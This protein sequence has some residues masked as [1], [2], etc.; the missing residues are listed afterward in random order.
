MSIRFTCPACDASYTIDDDMRGKKMRCR[1]CDESVTVP[2]KEPK[3]DDGV[4]DPKG[5]G[6]PPVRRDDRRDRDDHDGPKSRREKDA[7]SSRKPK[8]K[9]NLLL[10][11]VAIGGGGIAVVGVTLLLVIVI[12]VFALKSSD[13]PPADPRIVKD[14]V[15]V[16]PV[17]GG[18][19]NVFFGPQA[20]PNALPVDNQPAPDKIAAA[21][22]QSVK[23]STVYLRVTMPSGGVAEG[24]GFFA[25]EPGIVITNAHVVGMMRADSKLPANVDVVINSGEPNEVTLRG[26]VL[27]VDRFTDLAV[28]RVNGPA[29]SPLTINSASSLTDLQK[30]YYFGFPFGRKLGTN[31]TSS[32]AAVSSL[33][34]DPSG[35]IA[36]VQLTGNMQPGNS[37]GPVVD[38]AG[39]VVGVARAIISGTGINFAIP[40]DAIKEILDG[41]FADTT[42]G[43]PYL[44]N[45]ETRLP[46]TLK[47]IDPLARVKSMRVDIWVGNAGPT[48]PASYFTP[49]P[50]P[51]D[52]EKES[53]TVQYQ[54]GVA[55]A[56]VSLPK[57]PPGQV[58]WVQPVLVNGA[59]MTEYHTASALPAAAPLQ[60]VAA[61][62]QMKMS[63]AGERTVKLK[64]TIKMTVIEGK[65]VYTDGLV[66]EASV[67]EV[68]TPNDKGTAVRLTIGPNMFAEETDGKLVPLKAEYLKRVRDLSPNFL[69]DATG[70]LRQRSDPPKLNE[71]LS[72]VDRDTL[73]MMFGRVCNGYEGS[74]LFM[75]NRVVN[76]MESW[77]AK[78]PT[79]IGKGAKKK[80]Y[81]IDLTCSYQGKR[82]TEG[83]TEAVIA[84]AGALRSREKADKGP[85]GTAT[86]RAVFDVDGGYV[87]QLTLKISSEPDF[88]GGMQ[89]V[90]SEAIELTRT[91]GNPLAIV[92]FVPKKVGTPPV[93]AKG[94]MIFN[95]NTQLTAADPEDPE[96]AGCHYKSHDVVLQAGKKYVI[97]MKKGPGSTID[98]YLKLFD[99]TGKKVAEDDDSGGD[100]NAQITY[101]PTVTGKYRIFATTYQAGETGAYQLTVT[102][103][104]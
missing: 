96:A 52:G 22:V 20:N 64:D 90:L 89:M 60:R 26:N 63:K 38:A 11:M 7:S 91:P 2:A 92:P 40:A 9:G 67:L 85:L 15:A 50:R 27:G 82:I 14:A 54:N 51:G 28:V 99:A 72:Q 41:R 21:T 86:G 97:D 83:R 102:A 4:Y 94:K 77:A 31:V 36:Q 46:I 66:Y 24:S 19:P 58:Y 95:V 76:A 16:G 25:I 101:Q 39:R 44:H 32:E 87:S 23:A 78:V 71:K 34:K 12:L 55:T 104:D 47:A 74:C 37:G 57:L 18:A 49:P 35:A 68:L 62:L 10:P 73:E 29:P 43:D 1:K 61:E 79:M 13:D 93:V 69:A 75:P 30:V 33:R 65:H 17:G 56:E 8:K 98:P 88:G 70:K 103:A 59:G 5:R 53:I 84:L 3:T 6:S 42:Y 45:S 81:D 48:R 80:V 100:L